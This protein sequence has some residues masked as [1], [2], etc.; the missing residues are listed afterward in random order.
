MRY[1]LAIVLLLA[2]SSLAWKLGDSHGRIH[3]NIWYTPDLAFC[4][5]D[6]VAWYP[7]ADKMHLADSAN[8][9][10]TCQWLRERRGGVR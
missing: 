5:T 10:T 8:H 9:I 2:C 1:A 7:A 6:G 4:T 3:Q